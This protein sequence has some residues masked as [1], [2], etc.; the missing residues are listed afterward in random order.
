MLVDA[1]E[2]Q[3]LCR[4]CALAIFT[5]NRP[6]EWYA[7]RVAQ[8]LF[9]TASHESDRFETR[10]QYGF[11]NGTAAGGWGLMQLEW[12]SILDSVRLLNRKV[13]LANRVRAWLELEDVYIPELN[14]K[15]KWK[16]LFALKE[17][18]G[19]RLGLVLARLHYLRMPGPVPED[20]AG[21]AE[22]AKRYYNT[23]LGKATPGMYLTK[24]T[25]LWPNSYPYRYGY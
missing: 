5:K 13:A 18:R 7:E 1:V 23:P 6:T 11:S 14:E 9:M 4:S 17:Q 8:L 3:A 16:I 24:F 19:D 15:S 12:G 22:Y 25:A 10:R 20:V 2:F 21:M